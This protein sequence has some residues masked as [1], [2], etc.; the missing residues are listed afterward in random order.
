[1]LTD[2]LLKTSLMSWPLHSLYMISSMNVNLNVCS[3]SQG[4]SRIF[5]ECIYLVCH[6]D[7]LVNLIVLETEYSCDVYSEACRLFDSGWRIC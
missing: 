6:L 5:D 4:K 3:M 1:M 7:I 2:S